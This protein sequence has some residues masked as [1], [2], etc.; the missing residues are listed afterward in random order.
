MVH[1]L[2]RLSVADQAKWKPAFEEA[3]TFRKNFG[4][5]GVHAFAKADN[6]NEIVILGT[7]ES[8]D[9]AREMFQS[10]AFQEATQKAGV[11]GKPEVT[12]LNEV[13]KLAS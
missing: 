13:V 7:Y 11:T 3:G 10:A 9:K 2:V 4:S 1:V 5:Q 6:P 8:A 12:F